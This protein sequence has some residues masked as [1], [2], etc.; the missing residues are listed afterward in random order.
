MYA[1]FNHNWESVTE[2][3]VVLKRAFADGKVSASLTVTETRVV[4]KHKYIC[5]IKPIV[6]TVTE[7][8]V[9]LKPRNKKRAY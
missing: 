4:L 8:R 9:V 5:A 1:S 7:T 3:R 2:T 6:F